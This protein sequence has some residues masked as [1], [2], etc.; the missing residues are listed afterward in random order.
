M[1][2]LNN[3][4]E[5]L[6]KGVITQSQFEDGCRKLGIEIPKAA[7]AALPSMPMQD[8]APLS[9]EDAA[10]LEWLNSQAKNVPSDG[11]APVEI[12]T[13]VSV[14]GGVDPNIP[15]LDPQRIREIEQRA[16]RLAAD[17]GPSKAFLAALEA[18]K[19]AAGVSG[20]SSRETRVGMDRG[21]AEVLRRKGFPV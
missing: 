8:D 1:S 11:K 3:L 13:N 6:E 18:Q 2:K 5:L 20:P 10:A 17:R 19:R 21:S 7:T 16:A 14:A 12:A 4:K 15:N 9:K